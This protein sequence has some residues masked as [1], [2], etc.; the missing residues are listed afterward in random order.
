[1]QRFRSCTQDSV[2]GW[3]VVGLTQSCMS[4]LASYQ[5]AEHI[6][7]LVS[8]SLPLEEW[9]SMPSALGMKIGVLLQIECKTPQ[10]GAGVMDT[11]KRSSSQFEKGVKLTE[12]ALCA[13]IRVWSVERGQVVALNSQSSEPDTSGFVGAFLSLPQPGRGRRAG[14]DLLKSWFKVALSLS[15][16]DALFMDQT[17]HLPQDWV[18]VEPKGWVR[19]KDLS[20]CPH[21]PAVIGF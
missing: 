8:S 16:C 5:R 21:A 15:P 19:R 1:M 6:V 14:A 2:L 13:C 18:Q 7:D 9:R 20:C 17:Q 3:I 10:T 4:R 12:V 11:G